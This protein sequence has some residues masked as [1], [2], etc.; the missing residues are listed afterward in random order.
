MDSDQV[1]ALKYLIR[2]SPSG[3]MN[4]VLKYLQTLVGGLDVLRETPEAI[5]ALRKW[6]ET[7]RYHIPLPNKEKGLVT[8]AGNQG[9]SEEGEFLY[10]DNVLGLTFSFNPLTLEA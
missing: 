6:Y 5:A 2:A 7:H 1:K 9:E 3:E 10:Y 4:D 8:P